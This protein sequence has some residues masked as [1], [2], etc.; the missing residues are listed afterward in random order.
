MP[1]T[2]VLITLALSRPLPSMP[3]CLDLLSKKGTGCHT[4]N[5]CRI[6]KARGMGNGS[7]HERQGKGD[8]AGQRSKDIEQ[9]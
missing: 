1:K 8:K 6:L 4:V 3:P 7:L 9:L 5:F 2:P